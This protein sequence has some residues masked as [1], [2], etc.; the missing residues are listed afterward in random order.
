MPFN[1]S[2]PVAT[3]PVERQ[4]ITGWK[5]LNPVLLTSTAGVLADNTYVHLLRNGLPA[6]NNALFTFNAEPT[7]DLDLCVLAGAGAATETVTLKLWGINEVTDIGEYA[8]DYVGTV[9]ATMGTATVTTGSQLPNPGVWAAT[10]SIT[11]HELPTAPTPLYDPANH[12][13]VLRLRHNFQGFIVNSVN[14][15][16]SRNVVVLGRFVNGSK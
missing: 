16:A 10:W 5:R 8:V 11:N 3:P 14:N 1:T 9:V 6:D 4:P 12:K 15:T 2:K 7:Y 13:G